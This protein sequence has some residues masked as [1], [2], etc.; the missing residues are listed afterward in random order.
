MGYMSFGLLIG[1]LIKRTGIALFLYIT[2][3]MFI[4]LVIRWAIHRNI[5]DNNSM[6]FYPMNAI[7]DLTPNPLLKMTENFSKEVDFA[8]WLTPTEAVVT[9]LVYTVIF[10]G[11][12][13][14]VLRKGAL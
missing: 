9:T 14:Q 11:L 5:F 10:L 8:M 6:H 3:V 1:L 13:Y 2:Y 7:E 12:S 4:E